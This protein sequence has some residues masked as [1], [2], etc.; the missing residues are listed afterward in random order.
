MARHY[1]KTGKPVGMPKGTH[2]VRHITRLK[3]GS[4]AKTIMNVLSG[5]KLSN[6]LRENIALIQKR[7]ADKNIPVK[8]QAEMMRDYGMPIY[9]RKQFLENF[10]TGMPN[11]TLEE[12]NDWYDKYELFRKSVVTGT[13]EERKFD[14]LI[15]NYRI[16]AD[17]TGSE[18]IKNRVNIILDQAKDKIEEMMRYQKYDKRKKDYR[19]ILPNIAEYYPSQQGYEKDKVVDIVEDLNTILRDFGLEQP[20][21]DFEK[22]KVTKSEEE[23]EDDQY[24]IS[25]YMSINKSIYTQKEYIS[26]ARYGRKLT[27]K[28]TDASRLYYRMT[29]EQK[30]ELSTNMYSRMDD[31]EVAKV[32]QLYVTTHF[33]GRYNKKGQPYIPFVKS[34]IVRK[35]IK[36][37]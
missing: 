32:E 36:D 8:E 17:A 7:Y 18:Y 31:V 33:K 2:Y 6:F 27:N 1:T 30:L 28:S 14:M 4:R 35:Y 22:Y 13:E 3:S 24:D 25:T 11:M 21:D 16:A 29:R 10:K 9:T 12:I 15:D 19:N 34:S 5:E 20:K 23:I 37:K 26:K